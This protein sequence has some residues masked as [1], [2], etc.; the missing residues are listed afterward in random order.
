M[1]QQ[2]LEQWIDEIPGYED[3]ECN[4]QKHFYKILEEY[5]PRFDDWDRWTF[6]V[7]NAV[8]RHLSKLELSWPVAC[9]IWGWEQT[10]NDIK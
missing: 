1:T 9:Q 4:C 10:E 2:E 5:P 7:H 3:L 6:D 8:N